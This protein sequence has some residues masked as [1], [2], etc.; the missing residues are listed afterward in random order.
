MEG[1]AGARGLG[2]GE[3]RRSLQEELLP[4]PGQAAETLQ[5]CLEIAEICKERP[6]SSMGAVGC[7]PGSPFGYFCPLGRCPDFCGG[8][9]GIQPVIISPVNAAHGWIRRVEAP[10]PGSGNRGSTKYVLSLGLQASGL[11]SYFY[12]SCTDRISSYWASCRCNQDHSRIHTR[13]LPAGLLTVPGFAPEVWLRLRAR[14]AWLP[15]GLH[16]VG[17]CFGA[18]KSESE[19]MRS[20]P[21]NRRVPYRLRSRAGHLSYRRRGHCQ[22]RNGQQL[23]DCSGASPT[24]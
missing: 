6:G 17:F 5:G 15:A 18:L 22:P 1:R 13:R 23:L 11:C 4:A 3:A 12:T 24:L 14:P 21:G 19:P 20:D 8:A 2:F 16:V 10:L 7:L 9:F